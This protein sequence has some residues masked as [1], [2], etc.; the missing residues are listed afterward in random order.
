M[1]IHCNEFGTEMI[2]IVCSVHCHWSV[3]SQAKQE[4]KKP[5]AEIPT[6]FQGR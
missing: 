5:E 4:K 2:L 3:N 6:G 1:L